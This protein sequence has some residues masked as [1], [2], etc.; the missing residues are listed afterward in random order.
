MAQTSLKKADLVLV[1]GSSLQV[2]P[3]NQLPQ[4]CHGSKVLINNEPVH[5]AAG[6]FD[7]FIEGTAGEVLQQVDQ[8]LD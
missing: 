3:A 2:Y 5:I 6:Q 4:F 8:W 1:I 7:L